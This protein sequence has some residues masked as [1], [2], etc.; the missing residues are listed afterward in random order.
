MSLPKI[1]IVVPNYNGGRTIGATLQSVVDQNYPNLELLVVD[2]GS[3]DNSVEIIRQFE[4]HITWWTSEK[5]RGQSHAINKGFARATGDVVNWLCSDDLLAPNALNI[6]GKHFADSPDIDVLVGATTFDF[7]ADGRQQ[8]WAVDPRDI[9]LIPIYCVFSQPSAFFHRK[10]LD[11]SPPLDE[12][13]HYAMDLELWA[14]FK[15]K[16][17]R[18]T[19]INDVLSTFVRGEENKTSVGGGKIIDEYVRVYNSYVHERIP[20]TFWQRHLRF[21]L[22]R[23]RGKGDPPVSFRLIGRPLQMATVLLLG[24]FYGFRRVRHMNWGMWL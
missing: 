13:Y 16:G 7:R 21:P 17:A 19:V 10:L 18:Y 14:Y 1:S 9:D 22:E 20:L 2:G 8:L 12:S 24:P 11:R 4:P 23:W 5:D 6:V 3:T 15:S